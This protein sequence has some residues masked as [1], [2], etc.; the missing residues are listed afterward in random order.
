MFDLLRQLFYMLPKVKLTIH[1]PFISLA[2]TRFGVKATLI[3]NSVVSSEGNLIQYSI[4]WT[5][6]ADTLS[7]ILIS[8]DYLT[9]S[10]ILLKY[11]SGGSEHLKHIYVIL[12][13]LKP[14]NVNFEKRN[15][16][17]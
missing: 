12:R 4:S 14:F 17:A 6:I 13:I 15:I 3:F 11:L 5:S 16:R 2:A 9:I 7:V 1:G 10:Q 8:G